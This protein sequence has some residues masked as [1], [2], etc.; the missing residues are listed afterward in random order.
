MYFKNQP[1]SGQKNKERKST[2]RNDAYPR[3]PAS[4]RETVGRVARESVVSIGTETNDFE[5]DTGNGSL[6]KERR[7]ADRDEAMVRARV[8][9]PV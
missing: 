5:A 3:D 1:S 7:V 9:T 2:L 6:E 4:R 8:Y